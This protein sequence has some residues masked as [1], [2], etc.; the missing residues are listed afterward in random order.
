MT[1]MKKNHL[2]NEKSPYLL[3][4]VHNPVDWYPWG[5][6][7]FEKARREDK[8][9]LVSIG[10][11]T[12]HW[13]HVMER[14]SYENEGLAQLMNEYLVNIKLDREERPEVDKIYMTAVQ[15]MTGSGGWPLNVFLTPDLQ[16]FY[17]GTYF[18]PAPRW[19]V[20]GWGDVVTH[21]GKAWRN[22][23]ERQKILQA[24]QQMTDALK[25]YASAAAAPAEG[26]KEWLAAA[27][28]TLA[29]GY[30]ASRGGFG[31]APKFPMPVY[32]HFL[33]RY[34]ASRSSSSADVQSSS[35]PAAVSG[36]STLE[37]NV[38]PPLK[39][40]GDD[41]SRSAEDDGLKMSLHTLREM[42]RGGIYDHLGG[43]FARYSTDANWHIPH[44]EK[45]LYDN[46]QLTMNY[47]DAFQLS[48]DSEFRRIARETLD[49]VTRD[50]TAPQGGFYSAEDAD[51][52]PN[53]HS[54]HKTEGAFYVWEKSEIVSL[55]GSEAAELFCFRF[56]VRD[57]GNAAQDPHNEFIKKN[58]LY[59]AH[60]IAE[61]ARKFN[62]SEEKASKALDDARRTLFVAREARP[63]PHRDDKILSAWNGLMISAFARAYQVFGEKKDLHAAQQAAWFIK[64]NL[65][66]ADKA[67]L[68]RRWRDGDRKYPG[69]ADD[70]AFVVQGLI[71]LY[72][73]DFDAS[74]IRWAIDLTDSAVRQFY[75]PERGGFF[76]AAVGENPDLLV[77]VKEDQDNVEPAASSVFALALLRLSQLTGSADYRGRAEKTLRAF[78]ATLE[79]SPRAMPYMLSALDFALASS[80]QIVIAGEPG[81]P[82]T[83]ALLK[84]VRS[85]F[86][87][88]QVVMFADAKLFPETKG[89]VPLN[90]KATAYVCQNF[91]CQEPTN[92]SEVLGRQLGG[93][94]GSGGRSGKG[95]GLD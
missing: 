50:M 38:D 92:D 66:D 24:G 31:P 88:N 3:Q 64:K 78:G 41:K 74:W 84:V 14:E 53:D 47:L 95:E 7:A 62:L 33:L 65:Y 80:R 29:D 87:P 69:I 23:T 39:T 9:L 16:P 82:D 22:P 10:Y 71:D 75:D 19:G 52:L 45:M 76:M 28:Q 86:A 94:S 61:T 6:E 51:S 48:G 20:P 73:A 1:Q 81:A 13:C 27:V 55:L 30:D 43:G 32:H 59:A 46:A 49:Y 42:S 37:L 11:S 18:P 70:Y 5:L 60:P 25:Q 17:G 26:R 36:E 15:A 34:S 77:Q 57:D 90:G 12:C 40:A 44:F 83:E 79:Q 67:L 68:Y 63:R 72:E 21:I 89:H 93:K 2:A 8:P 91:A 54:L 58:I 35:F 85:R 4:H 56:G